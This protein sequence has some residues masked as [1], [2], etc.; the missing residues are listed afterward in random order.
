M[1]EESEGKLALS[2][3]SDIGYKK[4]KLKLT[5]YQNE[6]ILEKILFEQ[7]VLS[8]LKSIEL[9]NTLMNEA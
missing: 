4:R 5:N 8:K 7:V 3:D 2:E 9:I 6:K 1:I